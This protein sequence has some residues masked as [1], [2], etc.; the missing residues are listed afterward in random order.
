MQGGGHRRRA[1]R[2]APLSDGGACRAGA[3]RRWSSSS[4]ASSS[5]S[6]PHG[7][8]WP[9]EGLSCRSM[10]A[11]ACVP[12][13]SIE[14]KGQLC[15]PGR[16]GTGAWRQAGA[17]AARTALSDSSGSRK[18]S[19][20]SSQLSQFSTPDIPLQLGGLRGSGRRV[21][22]IVTPASAPA[23]CG[24]GRRSAA[25]GAAARCAPVRPRRPCACISSAIGRQASGRQWA[26]G[27]RAEVLPA[28]Q[29]MRRL[30]GSKAARLGVQTTVGGM[31]MPSATLVNPP[32]PRR[33][34]AQHAA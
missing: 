27:A 7:S 23:S 6:R 16:Q 14:V 29:P 34:S 9:Q 32:P 24:R 19:S 18:Q 11:E 10:L 30:Q 2:H 33:P 21:A 28:D 5:G 12:Q 3:A 1:R 25:N 31:R 20:S 13:T 4:S 22:R 26:E 17:P 8:S 15:R